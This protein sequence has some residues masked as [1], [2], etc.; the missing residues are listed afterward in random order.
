MKTKNEVKY[1]GRRVSSQILLNID[2]AFPN[3]YIIFGAK[4]LIPLYKIPF[5]VQ[6][7]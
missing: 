3:R 4:I 6:I 1:I 5:I 2:S 7:N